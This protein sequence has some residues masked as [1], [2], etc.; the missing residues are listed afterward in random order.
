MQLQL[1]AERGNFNSQNLILR[2][3]YYAKAYNFDSLNALLDK[4]GNR[5]TAIVISTAILVILFS[6]V[7]FFLM[8]CSFFFT[9]SHDQSKWVEKVSKNRPTV[10]SLA[11]VSFI[12]NIYIICVAS[13]AV[14]V[15]Y[16]HV[17]KDTELKEYY[18]D[19][20]SMAINLAPLYFT[21]YVDITCLVVYV[22]IVF[23]S[24]LLRYYCVTEKNK[25]YKKY[26]LVTLSL[27]A[28]CPTFCIIAHSPYIAIAYLNDGD[29][30]SSIFIYY[31]IL[32]Y[33]VFGLLWLFFHW[34]QHKP[35]DNKQP[36]DRGGG[37]Y[38]HDVGLAMKLALITS[39]PCEEI[40]NVCKKTIVIFCA[41]LSVFFLLGLVVVIACY[42]VFIP[43]HKSISDA[44]N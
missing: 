25:K 34:C 42:L 2:V 31:T 26:E 20:D 24:I 33:V 19:T 21:L 15:W 23:F 9:E 43:I 7:I 27:T 16:D 30:A 5:I 6:L 11:V 36:E 13:S 17:R 22:H 28:L 32:I 38:R 10:T 8:F 1:Y 35:Q 4:D 40:C 14:E 41:F 39:F 18:S 3:T 37:R 29:H 12:I 44:P